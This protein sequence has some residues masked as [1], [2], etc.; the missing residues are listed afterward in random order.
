MLG[1]K[2][3]REEACSERE[4]GC[5]AASSK[6]GRGEGSYK[7]VFECPICGKACSKSSHL[8]EH[9]RTHSGDRPF[10]CITCGKAF[11]VSSILKRHCTKVHALEQE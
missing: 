5:S 9:M 7:L 1:R 8:T 10:V 6:R 4:G 3:K 11:S 2:Q